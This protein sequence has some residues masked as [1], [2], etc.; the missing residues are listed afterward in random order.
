M[1]IVNDSSRLMDPYE[2]RLIDQKWKWVNINTIN[3]TQFSQ[4]AAVVD[5]N[6]RPDRLNQHS[7]HG[8]S[9]HCI[10]SG[11]LRIRRA[12]QPRLLYEISDEKGAKRQDHVPPRT[13]YSATSRRGCTFVEGHRCLSP[14]S[15]ERFISRGTLKVID[16]RA[17]KSFPTNK[18]LGVWLRQVKFDPDGKARPA[19]GETPILD[20][21]DARPILPDDVHADISE[22]FENEWRRSRSERQVASGLW[23][24]IILILCVGIAYWI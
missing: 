7:H 3:P 22:W 11:D 21:T 2:R 13:R 20:A 5:R 15:A 10:I 14:E 4:G 16:K 12:Y 23:S 24:F 1:E 9:T 17:R 18:Q 8:E 19:T 6:G